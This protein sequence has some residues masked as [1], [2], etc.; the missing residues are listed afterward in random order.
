MYGLS[1]ETYNKIKNVFNKYPECNIKL[2]GS[3][4]KG[5]YKYNSDIDIALMNEISN[6]IIDKIR[7]DLA[8]LDIIYKI[9]F[10][11]VKSCNNDK[12]IQNI[13]NEGVDF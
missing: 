13:I 6:D 5:S 9:D 12:L 1:I 8:K 3:R 4:A 10:V 2:F 7:I 11:V